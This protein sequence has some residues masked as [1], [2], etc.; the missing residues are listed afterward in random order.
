MENVFGYPT[1][2]ESGEKILTTY[3]NEYQDMRMDIRVYRMKA[4]EKRVFVKAGEETAVLLLKGNVELWAEAVDTADELVELS[5]DVDRAA[6]GDGAGK[7]YRVQAERKDVFTAGPYCIHACGG[8]RIE[9]KALSEA[10]ILV[11][12]TENNRVFEPKIYEPKDVSLVRS[13]EGKF[14]DTAKRWVSTIFDAK[15]APY[16]NMVLGEILGDRGNWSSY[17]P[18]SH[19]QPEVYYFLFDR[20]EGFGASFVGDQVF[21]S[22]D[23]SFAAISGGLTHPQATAPGFVMYTCWMIRH[24]EGKR[25]LQT[26]RNE[27]ARYLWMHEAKF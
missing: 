23:G 13:G 3:S 27:D 16:S 21:R 15:T 5:P 8:S 4:G 24:L 9:V 2:D 14:G 26:D 7:R 11:Q 18:H 19:P 10:E 17:L 20:P 6:D 25:W 1:F 12:S 22:T